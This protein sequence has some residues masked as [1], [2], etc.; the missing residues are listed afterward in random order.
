[1]KPL[2][3]LLMLFC[4]VAVEAQVIQKA[5]CDNSVYMNVNGDYIDSIITSLQAEVEEL[6][7]LLTD[8]SGSPTVIEYSTCWITN[9]YLGPMQ[10]AFQDCCDAKIADGWI[11]Q[12]GF[13]KDGSNAVQA[14]VKY[15][16]E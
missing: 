7:E 9:N 10:T 8:A 11:P 15:N 13:H 3:T 6:Q 4:S 5:I 1:M 12:G 14:F 16:E 2:I